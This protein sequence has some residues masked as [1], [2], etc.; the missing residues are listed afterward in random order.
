MP[1]SRPGVGVPDIVIAFPKAEGAAASLAVLQQGKAAKGEQFYDHM[2]GKACPSEN[3]HPFEYENIY[4]GYHHDILVCPA[5]HE[6]H[7]G[8]CW[9]PVTNPLA[10][11]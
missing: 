10:K 3:A 4:E 2:F 5:G 9:A 1:S 8:V 6:I 11:K 7:D